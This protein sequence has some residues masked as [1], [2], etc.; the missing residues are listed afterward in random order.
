MK[1]LN[2][3][4]SLSVIVTILFLQANQL[5]A[6][7]EGI[8]SLQ[9]KKQFNQL[10]P[11]KLEQVNSDAEESMP[12][13]T[14]DG[15][16]LY[17]I[18]TQVSSKK[19]TS[20]LGQEIWVA[21]KEGDS[22]GTSR[23]E[24]LKINDLANNA[25]V[26]ASADGNTI[27]LFNSIETRHKLAKGLGYMTK[28]SSGTWGEIKKITIPGFEIGDGYYAFYV[29]PDEN[30]LLVSTAY[31]TTAYED[32][33]VSEKVEG[34]WT[35]LKSLGPNVNTLSI[36]TSPFITEDKQTL[37]FSSAGHGGYGEM[38]LFKTTRTGEGWDEWSTPVNLGDKINSPY[39]DAYLVLSS[40]EK[41]AYFSSNRGGKYSDIYY[42]ADFDR[43][44]NKL[45]TLSFQ[46]SKMSNKS[47]EVFGK[48]GNLIKVI[49][50]DKNGGFKYESLE[51]DYYTIDGVKIYEEEMLELLEN[52]STGSSEVSEI[53]SIRSVKAQLSAIIL[54]N[55]GNVLAEKSI[56]VFG[57]DG[58]LI[59]VI[60][61]DKN[62]GFKYESLEADYYTIDGVKIYEEE[63]LELLENTSTV[64]SEV[65]EV[66]SIRSVKAQLRAIILTNQGN[67]L[68]EKSIE[69]FGR[70]GNLIKVIIT[71][72]NGGFKYES[73]EADY[74]MIDGI[75]IY[76]DEMLNFIDKKQVVTDLKPVVY[77]IGN[78]LHD[79]INSTK[80]VEGNY[81]QAIVGVV[82]SNIESTK[83]QK[84]EVAIFGFSTVEAEL[85]EEYIIYFDF[86]K[87]VIKSEG[88][89]KINDLIELS[90]QKAQLQVK[91]IGHT[92][93]TGSQ[94]Y[95]LA[96]SEKRVKAVNDYL[97][98]K[99]QQLNVTNKEG[100]GELKPA[101]D[102]STIIGR[103]RNRRVEIKVYK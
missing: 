82:K 22:L 59:K 65:L 91:L 90:K 51:A 88:I 68:A 52:T 53:A 72:K 35:S 17:F 36:E 12:I 48:D 16:Q 29:T 69:V 31:D 19:K 93:Y 66:T 8:N 99:G 101:A 58:N 60:T 50:T 70:D 94:R 73:L 23:K 62:G 7:T 98:S 54:T 11:K 102:N 47:I 63:M 5:S 28:D 56:E 9:T 18:R 25:V 39:F 55:Q 45:L 20:K 57:K 83:N 81:Q 32:L 6:Q 10:E 76:K 100:I 74:Y 77:D 30:T 15:H 38:D 4:P 41:T 71:D 44:E 42:V 67:V 2:H 13:V 46:G 34:N 21:A 95:N 27:Y 86:D 61:T 14:A 1:K 75:K 33:Y 84:D 37:Y 24:D 79:S 89:M 103:A 3:Y 87:S 97:L 49:I 64:S 92:D 26:G 40:D 85:L 96:L 43:Q 80:D 78:E